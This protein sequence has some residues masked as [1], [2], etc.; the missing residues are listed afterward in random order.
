[1]ILDARKLDER[2][3]AHN[4]LMDMLDL[5]SYYGKNLDALYDCLTEMEYTEFT[6]EH[7]EDATHYFP[8]VLHVFRDAAEENWNIKFTKE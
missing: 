1:M 3:E 6:F 8:V 2:T 5:P 4:Y 7:T